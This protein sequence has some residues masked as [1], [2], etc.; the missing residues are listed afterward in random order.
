MATFT[1]W[2]NLAHALIMAVQATMMPERYWSKWFTDIPFT[3]LIALSIYLWR[4]RVREDAN[5]A[6]ARSSSE[7][8]ANRV[9][10]HP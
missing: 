5:V 10:A 4:P 2:A 8:H 9:E 7:G 6:Q 3:G 1:M